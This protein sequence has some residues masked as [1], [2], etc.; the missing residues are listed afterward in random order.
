MKVMKLNQKFLGARRGSYLFLCAFIIVVVVF[1]FFFAISM[2]KALCAAAS[3]WMLEMEACIAIKKLPFSNGT[4]IPTGSTDHWQHK[5][6][7]QH[8][9][10]WNSGRAYWSTCISWV[11]YISLRWGIC[12]KHNFSDKT[13]SQP[14]FTPAPSSSQAILYSETLLTKVKSHFL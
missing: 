14:A 5:A 6:D 2:P 10:L 12:T 1:F 8:S 4:T 3:M 9:C 11:K 13:D 7:L